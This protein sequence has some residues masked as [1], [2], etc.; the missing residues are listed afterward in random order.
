MRCLRIKTITAA[1]LAA[2]L[3]S[4]T[5]FAQGAAAPR[6]RAQAA[7]KQAA[8][9][10]AASKQA[11]AKQSTPAPADPAPLT[12]FVDD[13]AHQHDFSGSVLIVEHG[14]PL[15]ARQ[16]G[17]ANRAF[18][19]R[20]DASTKYKIASITKAFTAVLILQLHEQGRLDLDAPMRRYLPDYRGSGGDWVTLR[21][22]LNHT[23]GLVN[24]DQV[25]DAA[26]AIRS[27][28]PNYQLP[29]TARQL[30]DDYCS[31]D[32]V[33]EPGA[34]FDYNNCDYIALGLIIER[35]YG[36]PYEQV[37][38]Q[39]IID[40]LGL[41]DTG[42]L[43]QRD[44]VAGLADTYFRRDDGKALTPDL[45]AYPENWYAA[46]AMYSTPRDLATFADGW[47]GGRLVGDKALAA[48]I[49][50][51]LDDYGFGVWSYPVRIDG[52]RYHAV[53]RP[54]RIMG[55][56]AQL[57]RIVEAGLTVVVLAN[58]DATDLDEFVARIGKHALGKQAAGEHAGD[59]H[60]SD[61]PAID[62]APPHD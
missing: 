47:F 23:S 49:A 2:M 53:K 8:S 12:A 29:H 4:S 48:M 37:L 39:R 11:A 40:P 19:I 62:R 28:L 6:D 59:Q 20:N 61:K 22:L 45:P 32:L 24:F 7:W 5:A 46:G 21:Q 57:Y 33:H 41:K 9:K 17:L 10:Q 30:A 52:R 58:T 42:V 26:Q 50:P 14:K 56:Q 3:A 18:A 27:G 51:G 34:K 60:A 13:Y 35:A 36:Q 31:G 15:L 55:A 25:T 1:A 54:G 16:Y 44:I 38:Q 43:H